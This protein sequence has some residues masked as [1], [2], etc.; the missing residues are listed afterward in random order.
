M[1]AR[2]HDRI[3]AALSMLLLAALAGGSYYL[4]EISRRMAVEP[5]D[6]SARHEPDSF[7][8]GLVFTRINELGAPAFRMSADRMLHFPD[9][10]STE[11]E[12]PVLISLDTT[13]PRMH[14]V[15]DTGRSTSEGVET[16][17]YGNVVLTREAGFG[18]PKM[19]V[20]T[21]YV[22]L[23]SQTEIARTD[24]PVRIE[25]EGSVLTGVGM[26][27]DNAA[28]SLTVDSRVRGTWTFAPKTQ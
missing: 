17:L 18:E 13:K 26:E 10:D 20:R 2:F 11:Y 21:D 24:R 15:A 8:E 9:D 5:V 3:A 14:L 7:V 6:L 25:R 22:V 16:H 23:Y 1:K 19:T 12:R 28:R 4:A 27:F